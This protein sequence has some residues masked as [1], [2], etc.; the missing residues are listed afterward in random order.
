MSVVK[1]ILLLSLALVLSFTLVT[2]VGCGEKLPQ[3]EI[4]RIIANVTSA[5]YDTV[6]LDMNLP[7]TMKVEGGSEAGT[8]TIAVDSTGVIDIANEEMRMTM[9]VTMDIL[10]EG[11]QDIAV[12]VYIVG[13]W[14]YT[15]VDIPE[16]GEQWLKMEVTDEAWQQQSQIDPL[17]EFLETAVE[18]KSLGSETVNGI[19]CYVFE[20]VPDIEELG[21][22][23][24]QQT[25]GMEIMDF[26]QFDLAD[27]YK[28]LSVK[29]WIAKDSYLLMKAE[30]E[31]VL[32]ISAGDVGVTAD[33]FD[34]VT[35][36]VEMV[37]SFYDYNQPVSIELPPEALDA[38]ELPY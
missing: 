34:K 30:I 21:E 12:E 33:D 5:E 3:E 16:L 23:F 4:D 36:D 7:I 2:F 24:S 19:D 14:M 32:E 27:L 13:G 1:R 22:L 6:K 31:M 11:E 10:G 18:I 29:E 20:M 37:M 9:N 17:L 38:E 8:M 28:E 26:S 15:K 35:I 25:S